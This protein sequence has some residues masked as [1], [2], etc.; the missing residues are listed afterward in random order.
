MNL[1]EN[2]AVFFR[3]EEDGEGF[4]GFSTDLNKKLELIKPDAFYVFNK[5]PFILF[6][7][8]LEVQI[9]VYSLINL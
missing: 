6:F 3:E 4:V 5:Q 9:F 8:F 7:D 2:N 1:I